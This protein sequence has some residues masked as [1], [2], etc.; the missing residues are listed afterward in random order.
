ME[1]FKMEKIFFNH[2]F[3]DI[4]L[5]IIKEFAGLALSIASGPFSPLIGIVIYGGGKFTKKILK[6]EAIGDFIEDV[7]IST[8]LNGFFIKFFKFGGLLVG[9]LFKNDRKIFW[10]AVTALMNARKAINY[11]KK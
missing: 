4:T 2:T 9:K 5:L 1:I 10:F 7:G 6:Q 11:L 8:L 3:R